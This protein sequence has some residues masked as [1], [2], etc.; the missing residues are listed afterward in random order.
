MARFLH[1]SDL[2]NEFWC[3]L[4]K[5]P[6][7]SGVDAILIAGDLNSSHR[8][9]Y[10]L[11]TIAE[12][13]GLP[14][15]FVRGNHEYYKTVIPEL[16]AHETEVL[17]AARAK[18]HDIR[19]LEGTSTE[20]AGVRIIGATLWTD[21][22]ILPGYFDQT[23][24]VVSSLMNDFNFIRTSPS[25]HIKP[26]DWLEMHWKDRDAV[27]GLLGKDYDGETLVMT[28]HMPVKQLIHPL[29]E[30]GGISRQLSNAGFASD[31][32]PDISP[33]FSGTWICGHS[34]DNR[35]VVLEGEQGP[36]SFECNTRGYPQEER[37]IPFDAGRILN[38][39]SVNDPALRACP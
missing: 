34:H 33:L 22:N 4:P 13:S 14:V 12:T 19:V 31:M 24:A 7:L 39:P 35:S 38:I 26:E 6:D 10:D 9:A 25:A 30:I 16:I 5:F 15:L 32:W 27:L 17:D 29:R 1:W 18:G 23:K 11:V 8:H 2:H 20:V 3:D 37:D 21:L 28:H 36:V